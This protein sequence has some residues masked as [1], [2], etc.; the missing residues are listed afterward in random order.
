MKWEVVNL[1]NT[2]NIIKKTR[3]QTTQTE[4]TKT[5]EKITNT[6]PE[7]INQETNNTE[8]ENESES[9]TTRLNTTEKS[10]EYVDDNFELAKLLTYFNIKPPFN[11]I[12]NFN[13]TIN[14]PY[15]LFVEDSLRLKKINIKL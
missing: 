6:E 12:D 1:D 8:S 7:F 9:E 3:S 11:F 10:D 4:T 5:T 13:K 2:Y 15:I 14:I